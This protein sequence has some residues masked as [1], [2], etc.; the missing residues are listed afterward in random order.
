[1]KDAY[2]KLKRSSDIT[3]KEKENEIRYYHEII[4]KLDPEFFNN[5]RVNLEILKEGC[6]ECKRKDQKILGLEGRINGLNDYIKNK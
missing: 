2:E 5:H 4:L 3:L 1:M 6:S